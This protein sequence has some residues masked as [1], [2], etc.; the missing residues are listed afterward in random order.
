MEK[1]MQYIWKYRLWNPTSLETNDGKAVRIIDP[2]QLN[3][4]AGPD[5]FNAK[6]EIDGY[7]GV[8]NV[9]T[10]Y[11]ASDWKRHHHDSDKAYDSVILHVV[12]KDDAPVFR[13]NGERIPQ[14]V[15]H[16]TQ[17]FNKK[18]SELINSPAELP[19]KSE[20][21]QLSS[22]ETAEWM[23]AM[24]MERLNAKGKRIEELLKQYRGDWESVCFITF[25][26]ALGFGTNSDAFERLAKSLPLQ[27]IHKHSDSIFQIEALLFGQAGLL[28]EEQSNGDRYYEQ[29]CREY[30]FLKSKYTLH[31][32]E[33]MVWKAF[34]MRPQ[35]FPWRR[36]ALLAHY[37]EGGF[38]LMADI[39]DADSS[40]EK[41]R[42]LFSVTL[43]GYW[44]NHYTF[45]RETIEQTPAISKSSIDIILINTVAP[46][47]YVYGSQCGIYEKIQMAIELLESLKPESNRITTLFTQAGIKIDSALSSQAMIQVYNDYCAPRKCIFC[48]IGRK[49]LRSANK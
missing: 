20:I 7:M 46:L 42:E 38:R 34:R 4:D 12:D 3:T 49:I 28:E 25:A 9:E 37:L 11:R 5:F 41:L 17:E 26:R 45:F 22:V 10:H 23:Q 18:Y 16:C 47:Y 40:E 21:L 2:G 31:Q 48:R 13:T 27:L 32:P 19:C 24:A 8:G 6:I 43:T 14:M 44:S 36:I 1:L 39:L 35:N 30:A 29:L 33:G 15:M